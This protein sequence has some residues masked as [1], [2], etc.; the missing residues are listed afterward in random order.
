MQNLTKFGYRA[1]KVFHPYPLPLQHYELPI[2]HIF[3]TFIINLLIQHKCNKTNNLI[4]RMYNID[5]NAQVM[6][7]SNTLKAT[8]NMSHRVV[9]FDTINGYETAHNII[10]GCRQ[11]SPVGAYVY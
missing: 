2:T 8:V 7:P 6:L 11:L 9:G 5:N 1:I 10:V 3:H 4:K